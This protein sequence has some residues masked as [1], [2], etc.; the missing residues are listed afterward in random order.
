MDLDVFRRWQADHPYAKPPAEELE[1]LQKLRPPS[2]LRL[3]ML[4]KEAFCAVF[5]FLRIY[6]ETMIDDLHAIDRVLTLEPLDNGLLEY[7]TPVDVLERLEVVRSA[8]EEH[9]AEF[10]AA[11]APYAAA[12]CLPSTTPHPERT[13][14]EVTVQKA[15]QRYNLLRQKWGTV[16]R[17]H[18]YH[19]EMQNTP[20]VDLRPTVRQDVRGFITE[21]ERL[22]QLFYEDCI[23]EKLLTE[24]VFVMEKVNAIEALGDPKLSEEDFAGIFWR[25]GL[26]YP[27][28]DG[29]HRSITFKQAM[30]L[31]LFEGNPTYV[32]QEKTP[33]V[34]PEEPHDELLPTVTTEEVAA[35][36]AE[37]QQRL[38]ERQQ[39]ARMAA[40]LMK[41][42]CEVCQSIYVAWVALGAREGCDA[43]VVCDDCLGTY[44]TSPAV[45]KLYK[46]FQISEL[47]DEHLAF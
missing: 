19:Q 35:N 41:Q 34:A 9:L 25:M 20:V 45:F 46:W 40:D 15:M 11:Y 7:S 22:R 43:I 18:T 36:E 16:Q 29:Y 23:V 3:P 39:A 47:V 31:D 1:L 13:R 33:V 2:T 8:L 44:K 6:P 12:M 32:W 42:G 30:A 37:A 24:L 38:K 28:G 5:Q 27:G 21:G 4:P 10:Q 17:W 26:Q 14:L